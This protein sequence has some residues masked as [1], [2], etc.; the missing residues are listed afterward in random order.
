[1]R[2]VDILIRI[3]LPYKS[4]LLR[5]ICIPKVRIFIYNVHTHREKE[6]QIYVP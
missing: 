3:I 2:D 4:A 5:D 6:T 1:M